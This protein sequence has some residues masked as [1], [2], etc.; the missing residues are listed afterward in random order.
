MRKRVSA[1]AFAIGAALCIA[2][3]PGDASPDFGSFTA[4]RAGAI[5]AL[6]AGDVC[7]KN[8]EYSSCPGTPEQEHKNIGPTELGNDAG[9]IHS[10]AWSP[11]ACDD[12]TCGGEEQQEELHDLRE[13]IAGSSSIL[14]QGMW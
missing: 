9:E 3:A 13:L 10:C 12:H 2:A 7:N 5:L 1:T 6:L 11:G 4:H 14:V 8:C